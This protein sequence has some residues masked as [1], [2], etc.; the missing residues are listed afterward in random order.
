MWRSLNEADQ[1]DA[2]LLTSLDSA[3][4]YYDQLIATVSNEKIYVPSILGINHSP[5][6]NGAPSPLS[7]DDTGESENLVF[8][9][10]RGEGKDGGTLKFPSTLRGERGE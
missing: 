7:G 1:F 9:P 6:N 10:L 3:Q 8:S 2:C 5:E 4:E